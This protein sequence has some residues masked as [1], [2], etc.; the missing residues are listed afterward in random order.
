MHADEGPVLFRDLSVT[1]VGHFPQV[2]A[3]AAE[4]MG[5]PP[6]G[7]GAAMPTLGASAVQERLN[8]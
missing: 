3:P 8:W 5:Q 7:E 1:Q 6:R 2:A 4:G